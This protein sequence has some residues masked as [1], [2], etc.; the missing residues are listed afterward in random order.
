MRIAAPDYRDR[1]GGWLNHRKDALNFD[2]VN[3]LPNSDFR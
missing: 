1:R 2:F 3:T